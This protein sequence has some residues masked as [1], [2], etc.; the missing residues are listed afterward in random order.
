MAPTA[1]PSTK[2]LPLPAFAHTWVGGDIH[3]LAA[4][5]GTLYGYVPGMADVVTALDRR[6]TGI[7]HDAGWQGRAAQAFTAN[8]EQVSAEI[9]AV[10]LLV[11]QTGSIVDQLAANL[12][13]IENALEDAAAQAAAHGVAIGTAG[14]PPDVCYANPTRESWRSS[15]SA[16]YQQCI[17][18]A[19]EAKAQAAGDLLSLVNGV[20]GAKP[21][22][23]SATVGGSPSNLGVYAGEAATIFDLLADLAATPTAFANIV[24]EKVEEA[25]N[26]L[27]SAERA[28]L[29]ALE[30]ARKTGRRIPRSIGKAYSKAQGEFQSEERRL[31]RAQG[32]EFPFGKLMGTRVS[33]VPGVSG[34]AVGFEK[35]DLLKAA[36]DVPVVDVV[37]GGVGT[38]LNAQADVGEGEAWYYAYPLEAAGTADSIIV[39]TAVGT[40][41]SGAAVF[42][43]APVLGVAAG[44]AAAGVVAYGV[45]DYVHNLIAD[46]P[47]QWEEHGALGLIT[48]FGAAGVSTWDDTAHLGSDVG[49]VASAAWHNFT[50]WF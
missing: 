24:T 30:T 16:F 40:I 48:D 47:K 7:V 27:D 15:Y 19:D 33:D 13:T 37:L 1:S 26:A 8:W 34:L 41:V 44:V 46:M 36:A 49:H 29:A 4:L 12:A 43:G 22:G 10:G 25:R 21:G 18:A 2:L 11:I 6:V 42:A 28:Y 9:N 5:A 38:V 35:G 17:A 31:A 3:G 32:D 14:Q 45:G 23:K 39:G 20:V 50:S